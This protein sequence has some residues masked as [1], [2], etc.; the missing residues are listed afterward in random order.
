MVDVAETAVKVIDRGEAKPCA[1]TEHQFVEY[2]KEGDPG[3]IDRSCKDCGLREWD[4]WMAFA[5]NPGGPKTQEEREE[6][7]AMMVEGLL[8]SRMAHA[9]AMK[10][11]SIDAYAEAMLERCQQLMPG[12]KLECRSVG[13][14]PKVWIWEADWKGERYSTCIQVLDTDD[15]RLKYR[16]RRALLIDAY[17]YIGQIRGVFKPVMR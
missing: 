8:L 6:F 1:G 13:S 2:E 10:G 16:L 7:V 9:H 4:Y 5:L 12:F 3:I 17:R 11:P 14:M 15:E